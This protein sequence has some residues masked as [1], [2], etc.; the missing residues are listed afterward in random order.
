MAEHRLRHLRCV[1][2]K[3]GGGPAP[4]APAGTAAARPP[5]AVGGM[6]V[7]LLATSFGA[8]VTGLDLSQGWTDD[9]VAELRGAL[10]AH[11]LLVIHGQEALPAS[12]L[13]EF[14]ELFGQAETA[15]HPNW[16]AVDGVDGV[17]QISVNIA[18]PETPSHAVDGHWHTD[19][20]PRELTQWFTFLHAIDIPDIGRD[21]LFADMEVI[22]LLTNDGFLLKNED[23]LLKNDI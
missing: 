4:A 20:P 1:I 15:P 17:K 18:P 23:F 22:S 3:S 11:K 16:N 10:V 12:R 14:A 6:T 21:T 13:L 9:I 5:P 7:R 19:G 8:E 2:A